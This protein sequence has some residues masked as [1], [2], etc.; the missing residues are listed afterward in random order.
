[1]LCANLI[2]HC[3]E[4]EISQNAFQLSFRCM[5][6]AGFWPVIGAGDWQLERIF[7]PLENEFASQFAS[8][9]LRENTSVGRSNVLADNQSEGVS[10]LDAAD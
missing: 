7:S 5:M 3:P 6:L 1:M 10:N 8:A 2:S 4:E 9:K